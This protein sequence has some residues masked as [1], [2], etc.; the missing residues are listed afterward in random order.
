MGWANRARAVSPSLASWEARG[1][2]LLTGYFCPEFSQ[3]GG[4]GGVEGGEK[5]EGRV[6][7]G[8]QRTTPPSEAELIHDATHERLL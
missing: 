8:R 2:T 5:G 6:P 4:E 1:G 3:R 7:N